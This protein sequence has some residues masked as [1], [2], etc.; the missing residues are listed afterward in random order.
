MDKSKTRFVIEVD[1][2]SISGFAM[3]QAIREVLIPAIYERWGVVPLNVDIVGNTQT[4]RYQNRGDYAVID[5]S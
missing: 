4:I 2:K 3:D 5:G 1:N